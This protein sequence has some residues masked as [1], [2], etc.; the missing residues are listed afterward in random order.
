ML[1]QFVKNCS[2]W[3]GLTLEKFVEDCLPWEGPHTGAGEECEE[4]KVAEMKCYELTTTPISHTPAPLRGEKL[5]ELEV[6]L[7]PSKAFQI[8]QWTGSAD[9]WLLWYLL[10]GIC[11]TYPWAVSH[12]CFKDDRHV[13]IQKGCLFISPRHSFFHCSV[14]ALF[15][16]EGG[17]CN[18]KDALPIEMMYTGMSA[19]EGVG[20]K[21]EVRANP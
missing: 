1:E 8:Q 4:E 13:F 21:A 20:G 5:E 12:C 2:P 18:L 10:Q 9:R 16:Q 19:W 15:K 17:L 11:H 3:E 7:R 14:E 6:K